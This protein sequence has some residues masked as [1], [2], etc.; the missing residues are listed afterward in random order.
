[1]SEMQ[2]PPSPI[3]LLLHG[4]VATMVIFQVGMSGIFIYYAIR[5][6]M[7][8]RISPSP[9]WLIMIAAIVAVDAFL[10]RWLFRMADG[11]GTQIEPDHEVEPG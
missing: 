7:D 2:P 8:G 9:L 1:M 6:T 10:I 3:R 11:L 4:V 5:Q